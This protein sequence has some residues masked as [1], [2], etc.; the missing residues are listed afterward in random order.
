MISALVHRVADRSLGEIGKILT[1]GVDVL[2]A[3]SL[4]E[5]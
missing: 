5:E 4:K 2:A 3:V 1:V